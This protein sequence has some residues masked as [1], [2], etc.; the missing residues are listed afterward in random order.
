[1][2]SGDICIGVECVSRN[3]LKYNVSFKNEL[4]RVIVHG[5]FHLIGYDDKNPEGKEEMRRKEDFY[6]NRYDVTDNE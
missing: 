1:L 2:V 3:A 5:V 4:I 6:L